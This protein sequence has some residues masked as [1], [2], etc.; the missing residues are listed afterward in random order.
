V[1]DRLSAYRQREELLHEYKDV[2]AKSCYSLIV[3]VGALLLMRPLI[4]GQILGR[5]SAYSSVGLLDESRRLCDKAL[6]IDGESS[7]AWYQLAQTHMAR[8]DREIACGMYQKAVQV[9]P[10]H[11][12]AHFELGILHIEDGRYKLA[13]PYLEQ[14][15]RL[16]PDR[17]VGVRVAGPTYHQTALE[18]LVLC[19]EKE[20]DPRQLELV[21]REIRI[22]YPSHGDGGRADHVTP[23]LDGS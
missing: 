14:V 22:F 18:M 2:A 23:N 20:G 17:P 12:R 1:E 9:D 10:S 7:H 15:R 21:L 3:I 16:G 6:L 11:R 13:I 8:G 4:V 5:A 19:H